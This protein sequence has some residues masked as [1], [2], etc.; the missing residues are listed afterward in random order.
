MVCFALYTASRAVTQAYR[1]VLEPWDLTYTQFLVLLTVSDGPHTMRDIGESLGL[2]SGTL[3]PLLHRLEKR[4]FITR[5][6]STADERVIIVS[7]APAGSA[8]RAAVEEAVGCMTPA[9]GIADDE[10][11]A[12]LIAQIR[13]I[14]AGMQQFTK[15]T[16]STTAA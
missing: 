1:A 11:M 12:R 16:R 2:D 3:S 9:Y 14:T 6:R 7:L 13:G 5:T 4:G 8:M 10:E 15:T